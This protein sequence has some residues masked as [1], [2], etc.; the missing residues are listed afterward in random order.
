MKINI[1]LLLK[2]VILEI[3]YFYLM[4]FVLIFSLF[5]YFGSGISASSKLAQ[6]TTIVMCC[7]FIILPNLFN[8]FKIF[9]FKR[10]NKRVELN[11]YLLAEFTIIV[12]LLYFYFTGFFD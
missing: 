10:K 6:N 11:T 5:L 1:G 8:L 12:F 3:V 4:Y 7:T 9:Q 2:V